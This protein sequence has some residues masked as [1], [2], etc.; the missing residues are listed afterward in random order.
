M[1]VLV[2]GLKSA[3][4]QL[5]NGCCGLVQGDIN[6]QPGRVAVLLDGHT[7]PTSFGRGNLHESGVVAFPLAGWAT[8]ADDDNDDSAWEDKDDAVRVPTYR[9]TTPLRPCVCLPHTLPL[10]PIPPFCPGAENMV[11][12]RGG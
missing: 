5:L 8:A 7:T 10:L 6:V 11:G 4:G 1:R 12:V 9:P 2:S 3:S